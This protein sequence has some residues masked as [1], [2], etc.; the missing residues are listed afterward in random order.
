MQLPLPFL[1]AAQRTLDFLLAMQPG[2]RDSLSPLRDKVCCIHV[3]GFD[4]KLYL[5]CDGNQLEIAGFFDGEV[6][7]TMTGTPAQF[8]SMFSN[9]DAL[10]ASADQKGMQIAGDI[11]SAR[12]LQAFMSQLEF[13]WEEQLSRVVGDTPAHQ[14]GRLHRHA[15]Q[16]SLR[17]LSALGADTGEYLQEEIQ[18]LAPN[19]EIRRFCRE[20]DD[21]R[22]A[23]ERL[24]MKIQQQQ[25][26]RT[27]A[28][29]S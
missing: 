26:A 15:Q 5:L 9:N 4:V 8:V 1:F 21:L 6:D 3:S 2:S 7:V 10:F 23:V 24:D 29:G 25:L 22:D 12:A 16:W 28:G 11:A 13:D 14:I 27:T 17:T 19:S 18:V 20:V